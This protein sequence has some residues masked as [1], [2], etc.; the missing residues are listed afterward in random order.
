MIAGIA[1]AVVALIV[2][3]VLILGGGKKKDNDA[4]TTEQPAETTEAA[5]ATDATTENTTEATTETDV[6]G[7]GDYVWPTELSDS[8]RDYTANIDGT[9]YQSTSI[10]RV[11]I[12]GLADRQRD[13]EGGI[14]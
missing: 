3:L 14:G 13:C 6:S 12:K 1:A 10:F 4:T 5:S 11:E 7:V 2:G 9:I 8:W